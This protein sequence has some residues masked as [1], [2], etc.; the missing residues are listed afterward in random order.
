VKLAVDGWIG[1]WANK[2]QTSSQGTSG[3]VDDSHVADNS[4]RVCTW[5]ERAA[6][7]DPCSL[8]ANGI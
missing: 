1:V 2:H 6:V 7:E 5:P 8:A 4:R 3:D